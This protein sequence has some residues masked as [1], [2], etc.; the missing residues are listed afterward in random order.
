[1]HRA[2][3]CLLLLVAMD[4][5]LP[6]QAASSEDA[7]QGGIGWTCMPNA[8][9]QSPA[10]VRVE[11]SSKEPCS[12]SKRTSTQAGFDA[13]RS[14]ETA[15]GDAIAP[16]DTPCRLSGSVVTTPDVAA[17][18]GSSPGLPNAT[19]EPDAAENALHPAF[20]ELL[21]TLDA[22]LQDAP[23]Q[24]VQSAPAKRQRDRSGRVH[25]GRMQLRPDV[26]Q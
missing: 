5:Q 11:L 26:I 24:V 17:A 1:M 7:N 3:L 22:P 21:D 23:L 13:A 25:S 19:A 18:S 16:F 6:G 2:V 4:L 15:P 12:G 10:L 9:V 8:Q 20:Q 14:L